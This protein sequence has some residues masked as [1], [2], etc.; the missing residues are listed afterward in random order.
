MFKNVN[1]YTL[2]LE[3]HI[4][5]YNLSKWNQYPLKCRYSTVDVLIY[6]DLLTKYIEA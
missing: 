5:V 6:F 4:K 2:D 1:I 3:I